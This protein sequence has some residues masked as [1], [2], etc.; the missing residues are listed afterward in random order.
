MAGKMLL[1]NK[2]G[3]KDENEGIEYTE[4]YAA[5]HKAEKRLDSFLEGFEKH[6]F[7]S[8]IEYDD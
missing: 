8:K 6:G 7:K 2:F 5:R 1:L 3:E 4:Y